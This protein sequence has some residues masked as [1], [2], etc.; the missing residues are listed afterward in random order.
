MASGRMPA[1]FAAMTARRIA[2]SRARWSKARGNRSTTYF[3]APA[4]RCT[5]PIR[6]T[7]IGEVLR[8]LLQHQLPRQNGNHPRSKLSAG[9]QMACRMSMQHP[10]A[11]SSAMLDTTLKAATVH[12]FSIALPA[13]PARGRRDPRR[14]LRQRLSRRS[15]RPPRLQERDGLRSIPRGGRHHSPAAR[16]LLK[17]F[18]PEMSWRMGP[19]S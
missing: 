1:E 18:L 3:A 10:S 9:I 16:G 19:R 4:G 5:S 7:D 17:R 12:R 8:E 15:A 11:G 2:T 13:R 6:P 14:R